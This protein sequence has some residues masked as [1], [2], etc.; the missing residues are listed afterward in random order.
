MR[1]SPNASDTRR[2]GVFWRTAGFFTKAWAAALAMVPTAVLV[3]LRLRD[4]PQRDHAAGRQPL[5]AALGVV[6]RPGGTAEP[7]VDRAVTGCA[8]VVLALG[9]L[10]VLALGDALLDL[11]HRGDQRL[12]G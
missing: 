5:R 2:A 3:G 9:P 7:A 4:D 1:A 6:L 11:H 10:G 12:G 8:Q